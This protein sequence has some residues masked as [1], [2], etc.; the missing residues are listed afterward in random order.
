MAI[1]IP[2][3]YPF[4]E[5]NVD[6]S[7]LQVVATRAPGVIAIVGVGANGATAANTPFAIADIEESKSKFGAGS[8][9][10][11]SLALALL[12]SPRPSKIYGVAV[13]AGKHDEGLAALEAVH[14]V[15]F[16]G[17]A[18]VPAKDGDAN[19]ALVAL[20]NHCVD[21]SAAGFPRIGVMHV[22]TTLAKSN[23]YV[24]KVK[25]LSPLMTGT[26]RTILVAAR[27]A[28]RDG[29]AAD[30]ASAAMA[31]IAGYPPHVSL[32]LKRID[33][34][35]M[36]VEQQYSPTEIRELSA[37]NVNPIIDP[38]L[39]VGS[40]LHFAEG[41]CFST[42][43]ELTF[44]DVVR[45]LDDIDFRLKAGLIGAIGDARITRA[46]LGSVLTRCE[47]ILEQVH[48]AGMIDGFAVS[49]PVLDLLKIPEASRTAGEQ[50]TIVA[51]R[52]NRTVDL[53]AVVTLGPAVH[54]LTVR[55]V[56]TF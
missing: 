31:A 2:A 46:G 11:A 42:A 44:I 40:S 23:A 12:Q 54:R 5:V 50:Q 35:E 9:L 18:N 15:T 14:D 13:A 45:L 22:D 3:A 36:P 26:G 7:A 39:I 43:S 34:F 20:K 8:D 10:H 21:M 55:L 51:A 41:R 56:P 52:G 24:D 28:L 48:R 47:G 25:A 30:V 6:L 19:A 49:I 53:I 37:L 17:L 29:K 38:A 27:G 16:V 1:A 33:G 4:V 32:V